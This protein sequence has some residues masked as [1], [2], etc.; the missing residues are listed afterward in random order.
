L[1]TCD[2]GSQR[3]A[4]CLGTG[5]FDLCPCPVIDCVGGCSHLDG[6]CVKGVCLE[7][8]GCMKAPAH[9][10]FCEDGDPCTTGDQCVRGTCLGAPVRCGDGD[11]CSADSCAP[12]GTCEHAPRTECVDLANDPDNCGGEGVVCPGGP[13]ARCE[14]GHCTA[15]R[16]TYD[17]PLKPRACALPL[18]LQCPNM[19]PESIISARFV[20]NHG[21]GGFVTFA[22]IAWADGRIDD[23]TRGGCFVSAATCPS[24]G[25]GCGAPFQCAARLSNTLD[26]STLVLERYALPEAPR[27]FGV[28]YEFIDDNGGCTSD[29]RIEPGATLTLTAKRPLSER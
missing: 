28:F 26:A 27:D 24:A 17:G 8:S 22:R 2:D 12:S 23:P 1:C 16:V 10:D 21:R 20:G 9:G 15:C 11:L 6:P 14:G 4:T 3:F 18:L 29:G 13:D 5:I 19:P 7:G 25:T